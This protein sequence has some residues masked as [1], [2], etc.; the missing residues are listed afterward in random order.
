MARVETG[1]TSLFPPILLEEP[2][3]I[4]SLSLLTK[5]ADPGELLRCPPVSE[6]SADRIKRD[7]V[8]FCTDKKALE[9]QKKPQCEVDWGVQDKVSGR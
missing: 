8:P 1:L 3:G 2:S 9:T 4:D 6:E 7:L 5:N